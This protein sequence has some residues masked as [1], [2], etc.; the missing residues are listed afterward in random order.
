MGLQMANILLV[1][2]NRQMAELV[3]TVLAGLGVEDTAAIT[4]ISPR[5]VKLE[6]RMARAWL[7]TEL[8]RRRE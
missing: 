8:E 3:R 1:E 4:G 7:Q 2:D 6:W 5:M